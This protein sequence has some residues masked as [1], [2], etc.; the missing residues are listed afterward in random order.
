MPY[1]CGIE[2][3]GER[4]EWWCCRETARQSGTAGYMRRMATARALFAPWESRLRISRRRPLLGR[5]AALS[6]ALHLTLLLLLLISP[7]KRPPPEPMLPSPVA[8]VFM[9]PKQGAKSAPEPSDR[10]QAAQPP[11]PAPAPPQQAALPPPPPAPPAPPQPKPA[12]AAPSITVPPQKLP[13]TEPSVAAKPPP[14]PPLAAPQKQAL[15]QV[16]RLPPAPPPRPAPTPA[17]RPAPSTGFP[18]PMAFSL[19]RPLTT[20]RPGGAPARAS[21][22]PAAR[23]PLSFGR[24]AHVVQGHVDP[25]WLDQLHEWWDRHGY[26]P[27]EAV[28]NNEDGT[29]GIQI[30]VDRYGHVRSVEREQRSGSTWLD[31]AAVGTFRDAH[32]PPLPPDSPDNQITV[33]LSITYV[34]LRR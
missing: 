11:A 28:A 33:D 15:L 25:S 3:K 19:G 18:A 26:Y 10:S 13:A 4:V 16:P 21:Y 31:M 20:A 14:P 34:L 24:F 2:H 22:G 32:L 17:P 23:G 9:P 7:H 6:L 5:V 12:P 30:V 27:Q 8:M 1:L 29:V